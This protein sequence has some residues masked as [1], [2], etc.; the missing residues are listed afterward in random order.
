MKTTILVVAGLAFAGLLFFAPWS[1]KDAAAAETPANELYTVRRDDLE[2]TLTES[3]TMVAKESQKVTAKI[4]GESKILFLVEEGK[5]VQGGRSRLQARL[6]TQVQTQL[7]QVQLD[8]LQTE[9]NLKTARTELEI[10]AVETAANVRKAEVALD[11]AKKEIEKYRD[12]EAPQARR[13]LEVALKDAE[14]EFNRKQKNYEDSKKLLEQN[15]IKKAELE[16]H[17]IAFERATVQKEGA[18]NDL[19]MFD[20]YTF[21][22]SLTDFETKLADAKRE[23]ETAQ[24]RGESTL[25][26]KTVAVQQVEKRLKVQ[27]EQLKERKEDLENMTLK[28]PCPGIVVYGNP[29]EPW[30]RE[31]VKVGNTVYGGYTVMTIPDLREMQVKLQIHEADIS[32]LKLGL[33]AGVTTD[34]YPGLQLQGEVTKIA[35]V[36]SGDNEWG[37]SSEVKKFAVEVT[38]K[39]P[40]VQLRPG[41]SAKVEIHVDVREKTLF[42]PLQSVF[43]EDDAHWCYVQ[44]QGQTPTRRKLTIGTSND[45]YMEVLDGL[46]EGEHVLLYNPLLPKD[47]NDQADPKDGKGK[48]GKDKPG[49]G[50]GQPTAPTGPGP[51][52]KAGS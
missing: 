20:K 48:D 2:V 11:K 50:Q 29:H 3:G 24:K 35:T 43:A 18:V 33:K 36:A 16:D 15:Y 9:A 30:Y 34:S 14:T 45:N 31:R 51:G 52:P 21:P 37:G 41:I 26:Q 38:L 44:A 49:A 39:T 46:Q 25:G 8:I 6:R 22:M 19:A 27:Q 47:G 5:E 7:E 4:K 42:L 28:A 12:G 10:Q 13:K 40:E 23:V 32:K 1:Q 17:Q